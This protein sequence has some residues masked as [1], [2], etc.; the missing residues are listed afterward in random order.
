MENDKD[1]LTDGLLQQTKNLLKKTLTL[2]EEIE[3]AISDVDETTM[4]SVKSEEYRQATGEILK[5]SQ[6]ILSKL[7]QMLDISEEH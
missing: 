7:T 6:Q 5:E 4:L 3:K 1:V 2:K